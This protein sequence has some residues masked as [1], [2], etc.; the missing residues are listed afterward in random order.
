MSISWSDPSW[1]PWVLG[2]V[3]GTLGNVVDLLGLP[4]SST[5]SP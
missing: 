4:S 2:D 5:P 1:G 3:T